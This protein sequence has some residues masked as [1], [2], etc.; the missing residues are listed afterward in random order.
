METLYLFLQTFVVAQRKI[1]FWLVSTLIALWQQ[2]NHRNDSVETNTCVQMNF[3][4]RVWWTIPV[5]WITVFYCTKEK[6]LH[7]FS[8]TERKNKLHKKSDF[9][10]LQRILVLMVKRFKKIVNGIF[11]IYRLKWREIQVVL[12]L[13]RCVNSVQTWLRWW[14]RCNICSY[15]I[16]S[17]K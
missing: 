13:L 1:V 17:L 6:C 7:M 2:A 4:D 8:I 15:I 3:T 14:S 9:S 10:F 12:C 5:I 16:L 11:V